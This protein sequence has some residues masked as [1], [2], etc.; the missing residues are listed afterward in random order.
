MED[1]EVSCLVHGV[2][3][4]LFA[5]DE[6]IWVATSLRGIFILNY[7]HIFPAL[8][9]TVGAQIL[10]RQVETVTVGVLC[11]ER[12]SFLVRFVSL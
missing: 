11:W 9:N 10:P 12:V 7:S 6:R 5:D 3:G 1:L 2:D 8:Q 4:L